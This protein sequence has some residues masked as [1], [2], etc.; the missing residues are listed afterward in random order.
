MISA[1]PS[2]PKPDAHIY[3]YTNIHTYR[4][5][6]YIYITYTQLRSHYRP[7]KSMKCDKNDGHRWHLIIMALTNAWARTKGPSRQKWEW[8]ASTVD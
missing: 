3:I 8:W 4:S 7:L 2:L 6:M 1:N 5:N